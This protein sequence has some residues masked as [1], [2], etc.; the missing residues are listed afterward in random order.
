ML[1]IQPR[2]GTTNH[3][4][5]S[6]SKTWIEGRSPILEQEFNEG[7]IVKINSL[8]AKEEEKRQRGRERGKTLKPDFGKS[9]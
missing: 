3:F 1:F 9:V 4:F 7:F 2:R 6:T 5:G 8:H